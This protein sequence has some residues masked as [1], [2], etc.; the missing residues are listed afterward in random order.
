MILICKISFDIGVGGGP[1]TAD[2]AAHC[3]ATA[4]VIAATIATVGLNV[5]LF[6][7]DLFL[8]AFLGADPVYSFIHLFNV[9]RRDS[10]RLTSDNVTGIRCT[11]NNFLITVL[12]ISVMMVVQNFFI[13]IL[14]VC[15]GAL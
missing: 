10:P 2:I 15:E 3:T 11:E 9:H 5:S 6:I 4:D 14:C 7:G 8:F 12:T 1:S 13:N